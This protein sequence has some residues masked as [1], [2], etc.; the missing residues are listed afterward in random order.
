MLQHLTA[1]VLPLLLKLSP[2]P[3]TNGA[4]VAYNRPPHPFT[5]E[6][7]LC[8]R[9]QYAAVL[10]GRITDHDRL[11][12]RLSICPVGYGFITPKKIEKPKL[13]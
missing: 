6:W 5:V 11:S 4:A 9:Y 12:V 7:V 1:T 10:I 2:P 3:S 8:V 13:V